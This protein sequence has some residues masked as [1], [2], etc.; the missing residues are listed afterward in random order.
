MH[1]YYSNGVVPQ[2]LGCWW[3]VLQEN[4]QVTL[5]HL[6]TFA[7]LWTRC[8][9][10]TAAKHVSPKH[11]F[12]EKVWKAGYDYRGDAAC[13]S[14][15]LS[16]CV[17]FGQEILHQ[18]ESVQASLAFSG[19]AL[20]GD[21]HFERSKKRE[22][23]AWSNCFQHNKQHM[24][25]F[26]GAYGSAAMRPKFHY[27]LHTTEQIGKLQR[28]IDCWP[29][30]RKTQGI[31]STCQYELEQFTPILKG[32]APAVG[33]RR[34]K[35][36]STQREIGQKAA[37]YLQRTYIQFARCL[38]D[39]QTIGNEMRHLRGEPIYHAFRRQS[40]LCAVFHTKGFC[41]S[42]LRNNV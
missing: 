39:I 38:R 3:T 5:D 41:L 40:F 28:H 20:L 13:S 7:S 4:T 35:L 34:P 15:V 11:L 31:Q 25:A 17:A 32:N 42:S 14:L 36:Q 24:R 27:V 1:G 18:V 21:P 2:E 16:L 6:S 30:E 22:F 29:C 19:S 10:T 8:P 9:G 12:H 33:Y 26:A 23:H 37:S